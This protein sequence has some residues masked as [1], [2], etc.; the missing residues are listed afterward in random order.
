MSLLEANELQ[1]VNEGFKDVKGVLTMG[2]YKMK[3]VDVKRVTSKEKT[4][5]MLTVSIDTGFKSK[6][7][8]PRIF[9]VNFM[10]TGM[11][12][13]GKPRINNLSRFLKESFEIDTLTDEMLKSIIGKELAVATKKDKGGYIAFW[14][15]GG[16]NN[17][18]RMVKT[19]NP[20]DESNGAKPSDEQLAQTNETAS[21]ATDDLPF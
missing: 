8:K 2:V 21:V 20:K 3:V 7:D 1:A 17:L 15:S 14:Y 13:N 16:I 4:E 11:D 9:F 6:E 18:I 10:L 5:P 12:Q 19:Y